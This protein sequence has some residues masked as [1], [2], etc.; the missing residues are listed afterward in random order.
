MKIFALGHRQRTGKDTLAKFIETVIRTR[1]KG[2]NIQ[3]VGF[4]DVLK[5]V[6]FNMYAHLGLCRAQFYELNPDFREKPLSNGKTPRQI[7][8]E[9]G[10]HMR[11][12]DENIW[13]NAVLNKPNVDVLI[14]K[15]LR[16]PNEV[17]KVQERGGTLIKVTRPNQPIV[18]DAADTPLVEFDGW[19]E[20]VVNDQGLEQLMEIANRLVNKYYQ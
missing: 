12:Y 5:D 7:W 10:N 13:V 16:F 15:D 17:L 11:Q 9:V 19:N 20:V 4:A 1:T 18:D 8:I 6:C 14:L 2:K 3:V